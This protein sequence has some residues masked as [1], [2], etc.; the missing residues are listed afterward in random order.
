[1]LLFIERTS[2]LAVM[3]MLQKRQWADPKPSPSPVEWRTMYKGEPA[4]SASIFEKLSY[5]ID[6]TAIKPTPDGL[7][8]FFDPSTEL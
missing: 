1:M 3:P 6:P 2:Q 5:F 4:Y 8:C 7:L